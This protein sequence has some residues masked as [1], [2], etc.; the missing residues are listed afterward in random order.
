M[1][2]VTK[3]FT[4]NSKLL[5]ALYISVLLFNVTLSRDLP[6]IAIKPKDGG[7]KTN[8]FDFCFVETGYDYTRTE[9]EYLSKSLYEANA[10]SFLNAEAT[11]VGVLDVAEVA[12]ADHTLPIT[13]CAFNGTTTIGTV[14]NANATFK[15]AKPLRQKAGYARRIVLV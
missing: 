15:V 6:I 7:T 1:N 2:S 11:V 10:A 5:L 3:V 13:E 9:P 8:T 4:M 14:T 12:D